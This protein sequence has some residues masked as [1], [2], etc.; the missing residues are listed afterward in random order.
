MNSQALWFLT[1]GTGAASLLLLTTSVVLGIS[2]VGQLR[3][4]RWPRFFTPAL[5]RSVSLLVL[6]LLAV[7]ILTAVLDTYVSIQLADAVLPFTGTYRPVWLGLGALA[8]DLLLA[9]VV[10]SVLRA[11]LGYRTWRALHWVAYACWPVALTHGLGT[12]TDATSTWLL[13]LTAACGAAVVIALGFR[14][15]TPHGAGRPRRRPP[16]A[17]VRGAS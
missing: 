7:H 4:G 15:V 16:T 14:L 9:L 1:R 2:T 10:S 11:R 5:H 8:F 13:A 17:I 6:T 12:G 3:L